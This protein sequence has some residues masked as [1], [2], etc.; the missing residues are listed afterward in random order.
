MSA[1]DGVSCQVL[2]VINRHGRFRG[3]SGTK[4][5]Q[6]S[7]GQASSGRVVLTSSSD[8]P[9]SQSRLPVK[10]SKPARLSRAQLPVIHVPVSE[11]R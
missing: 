6:S 8:M 3:R 1:I 7:S 2:V 9:F 10:T 11:R 4:R 5:V